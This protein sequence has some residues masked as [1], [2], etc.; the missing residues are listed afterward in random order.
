VETGI[1]E[2]MENVETSCTVDGSIIGCR[3]QKRGEAKSPSPDEW[4]F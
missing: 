4:I 1:A 3:A 2:D